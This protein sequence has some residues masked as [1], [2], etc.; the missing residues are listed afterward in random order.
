VE[1]GLD[2]ITAL[3]GLNSDAPSTKI[4]LRRAF[5]VT[6]FPVQDESPAIADLRRRLC[7]AFERS[8]IKVTSWGDSLIS[9]GRKQKV[10]AGTV[11]L[12]SGEDSNGLLA[13]DYVSSLLENTIVGLF[14]GPCPYFS[15]A[16]PQAKIDSIIQDFVWHAV[17]LSIYLHG[18]R[19]T[20]CTLN[21][22]V[23][24]IDNEKD[25]QNLI[26]EVL[27][28]KLAAP[29]RPPHPSEYSLLQDGFDAESDHLRESV[30]DLVSSGP[31]LR[32]AS[33]MVYQTELSKL[34]FRGEFYRRITTAFV[35]QRSGMS[36]G[37]I[38]RQLPSWPSAKHASHYHTQGCEWL[39]QHLVEIDGMRHLLWSSEMGELLI[40]LPRVEVL[41]TRS[42][43]LK[44]QLVPT[45]DL[46]VLTLLD[47]KYEVHLPS[48]AA[49]Q[50][51]RPSYDMRL[52]LAHA[53]AN[54]II[55]S[56]LSIESPN[57]SFPLLLK[58]KGLAQLHWHG[59]LDRDRI[60]AGCIYY[61]NSN[62][63]FSCSTPQS[64][65]IAFNSK[66]KA[67]A[68]RDKSRDYLGDIHVE[69]HHGTNITGASIA[70]LI[71]TH[72]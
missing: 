21:G 19:L 15:F 43:C 70:S 13:A 69:P 45:R 55:A 29:V 36:Y 32:R 61:G 54:Y 68:R 26:E 20:V 48:N 23:V 64:A 10:P 60:P 27:L 59:Y 56:V 47:G 28:T 30:D 65:I 66:L 7:L 42:G 6:C 51:T 16:E 9:K 34:R 24:S 5:S 3:L 12:T 62:P 4:E 72:F 37:F 14:D 49:I 40:P 8:G 53:L 46:V 2:T 31:L 41:C 67:F 71:E 52:I 35:D 22:A 39:T 33:L 18:E 44:M 63:P 58:E 57:A 25:L 11:I 50:D 1:V 38:C 17:Q